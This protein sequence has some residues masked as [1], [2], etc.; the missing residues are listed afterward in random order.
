[1][2]TIRGKVPREGG[3]LGD[4]PP[5]YNFVGWGVLAMFWYAGASSIVPGALGTIT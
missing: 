1:M 4:N 3:G 5:V 2:G